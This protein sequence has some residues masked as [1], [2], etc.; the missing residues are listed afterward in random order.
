MDGSSKS[1][2]IV[3]EE[4]RPTNT[5]SGSNEEDD[6]NAGWV[7]SYAAASKANP[8]GKIDFHYSRR[9]NCILKQ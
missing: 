7:D 6:E 9:S 8:G 4:E 1:S 2:K 5:G 3:P